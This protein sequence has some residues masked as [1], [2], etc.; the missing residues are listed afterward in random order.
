MKSKLTMLL[1]REKPTV[2]TFCGTSFCAREEGGWKITFHPVWYIV[3]QRISHLQM[4][5]TLFLH[6]FKYV[7]PNFT[8]KQ[9]T[10]QFFPAMQMQS[11]ISAR[12]AHTDIAW[13]GIEVKA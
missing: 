2:M 6:F 3:S 1:L 4:P 9:S 8:R 10:V 12:S 13:N 11:C 7:I 5:E